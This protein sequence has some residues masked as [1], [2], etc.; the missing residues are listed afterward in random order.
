MA[1]YYDRLINLRNRRQDF[2]L[3]KEGYVI[4]S[5]FSKATESY[6]LLN[7]SD[8]IKYALGA[9]QPVDQTYTDNTYEE[10]QRIIN[11]LQKNLESK[12]YIEFKFQGSVTNNTHIR[13]HSD[14]D[15]L[16]I[17]GGFVTLEPPL[18]P[19]FPYKG[20]PV[21]DLIDLRSDSYK[22]LKNAFPTAEIDNNGSKSISVRGGSLKR[23]IDVVPS[24]WYD[25]VNYNKT[26]LDFYRGIQVLD[27]KTYTRIVNTPF[28]HNELLQ[29][30]DV[31]S[32]GNYKKMVRL[33]KT[34]KADSDVKIDISSYDIA[35]IMYYMD[36]PQYYAYNRPLKLLYNSFIYLN[37]MCRDDN[38]RNSLHV[39][40]GSRLIFC[41]DGAKK[42]DFELLTG[43]LNTLIGDIM[44]EN[45]NGF[46]KVITI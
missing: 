26:K 38:Y 43:E 10:G 30:K 5:K 17:H 9:M 31:S 15:V 39:P 27:I 19:S 25:T 22:I 16:T 14:I 35:A 23:K 28:Y 20:N 12:Y 7:E 21:Q 44:Q 36:N 13:V 33:L 46:D 2:S 1:N 8:T 6:E 32:L 29:R 3:I 45:N 18:Q 24:N 42:R 34:L 37:K 40:D 4:D 41:D 11:Q